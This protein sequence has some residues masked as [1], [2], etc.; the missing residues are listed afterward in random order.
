M[1]LVDDICSQALASK[2]TVWL[3]RVRAVALPLGCLLLPLA[4][5]L[6]VVAGDDVTD[7]RQG[8]VTHLDRLS[9]QHLVTWVAGWEALVQDGEELLPD[10]GGDGFGIN[11]QN[12]TTE[13]GTRWGPKN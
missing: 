11:E 4:D 3:V 1:S 13:M 8:S 9:V 6:G 12:G 7:V 10:V 5:D 2:W